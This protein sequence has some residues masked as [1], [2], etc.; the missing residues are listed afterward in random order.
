[1]KI[2][3]N[4][5]KPFEP[6]FKG[7]LSSKRLLVYYGGRGGGKSDQLTIYFLI[8]ALKQKNINILV[9]REFSKSNANSL[10]ANF[11]NWINI[12]GLN[13]IF[14]EKK[15]PLIK[16]KA[17]SIL[18]TST[19]SRIIFTGIN[20]NTAP[21]IKSFANI[22]YCWVEEANY[23]TETT[24]R[25]LTP[26]IRANDSQI[27]MSFNPNSP[28]EFVWRELIGKGENDLTYI[29]RINY[30]E[31]PYF[32]PV[33]ELER[34]R[35]FKTLPRDLYLHIWEG[36]P[37]NYNDMQVIDINK[38]G[39]FDDTQKRRY[40]KIIIVIDSAFSTKASADYSV[41]SVFGKFENEIHLLRLE[42][43]HWDF[44]TLIE[45]LKSL[46]FWSSE[47]FGNVNEILIEK[48]A[49]GQSLI[50]EIQ[51]LTTLQIKP[52][53]PTTDKFTRLT[54]IIS[55]LELLKLPMSDNPLNYWINDFLKECKEFRA[56]L[57]HAHDD[58]IDCMIYA[59]KELCVSGVNWS[60]FNNKLDN[61]FNNRF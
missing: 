36:E 39:R 42:R 3:F 10:I 26:T 59:L 33:L 32:P 19:N 6:L 30:D 9:L 43:G 29:R 61:I 48:K 53:I 21:S 22:K 58:Q 55:H 17:T 4:I 20:D 28:D 13:N 57:K 45:M 35:D 38:I 7:E 1:M 15:E 16:I 50:Q 56:D 44:N 37:T 14:V 54:E 11:R 31:N 34:Q 25:I 41:V 51:R 52:V 8:Q 49:S 46:Y 47:K 18:C 40:S 2:K 12:L 23:L 60:D 24:Y 27:F 5:I